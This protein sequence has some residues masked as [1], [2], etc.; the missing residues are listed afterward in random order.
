MSICSH[1]S[2]DKLESNSHAPK[3]QRMNP[4]FELSNHALNEE[5]LVVKKINLY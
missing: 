1:T 3:Q 2:R 4:P 5:I